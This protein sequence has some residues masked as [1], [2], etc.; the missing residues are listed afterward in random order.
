MKD[1]LRSYAS[2]LLATAT[3][4]LAL[5]GQNL[6]AQPFGKSPP[7]PIEIH[8]ISTIEQLN[9]IRGEYLYDHFLLTAD[10]DFSGYTYDD[11]VKGW[12]PIGHDTDASSDD[13]QGTPFTGL[14]DGNGHVIRNLR[15]DRGGEDSV[16]LFGFVGGSIVSLGLEG[17]EVKGD[18]WVG[19]IAGRNHGIV[20]DCYATGSV[21]GN[22]LVG[23]LVGGNRFGMV[24][25]SYATGRVT[26]NRLVGGLVGGN[27]GT[28]TGSYAT[29][30][31]TGNVSVGGLV[32]DIDNGGTVTDCYATGSVTGD[33]GVG[34]LV[35]SSLRNVTVTSSYAT[36]R[37]TGGY[38]VGGVAGWLFSHDTV[39]QSYW[40]TEL[41]GSATSSTG[42][43]LT[44][45]EMYVQGSFEGFDFEGTTDSGG[46][47]VA[48]V[49][50]PPV[51]GQRFPHLRGVSKNGQV[52][53]I[54]RVEV[55]PGAAP[56]LLEYTFLPPTISGHAPVFSGDAD[57]VATIDA[58]TGMI[59]LAPGVAGGEAVTITVRRGGNGDYA[60][61][62]SSWILVVGI[63]FGGGTG[64]SANPWQIHTLT[65][66]N[67]IRDRRR[68][69]P[70]GGNYL[71]DHFILMND[72]DFADYVYDSDGAQE[73]AKGWLPIGHDT[74]A[75]GTY[76]S[77]E[78]TPFRGSFDGNGHVIRNLRIDRGGE[79]Y[80][81]LFGRVDDGSIVS[82]GLEDLEVTGEVAV[83][84]LV[85]EARNGTVT[86]SYATG[87][88]TGESGVGG[89][90]GS[91]FISPM[92]GSYAAGSVTGESGVGGLVGRNDFTTVMDSYATGSVTGESNVGGLVGENL[93]FATVRGSYATGSV[94]GES[95][96]GGLV[97]ENGS[98]AVVTDSYWNT[99]LSGNAY[100]DGGVGLTTAQMYVQGSFAGFDFDGTTDSADG[101]M[102]SVWLPPV[103]GQRFPHLR[104]VSKN[105]QVLSI[106][107]IEVI[108]GLAPFLLEYTFLPPTISGQAPVFSGD[109]DT[110]ATID[111]STGRFTLAPGVAGG[112]AMT[113]TVRRGGNGDYASISVSRTLVVSPFGGGAGT[114]ENPWQIST[115]AHLNAIRDRRGEALTG[116]NLL[117]DHFILMN[118]LDFDGYVYDS[119]DAQENTKGWLPIGHDTDAGS[120]DHQGTPFTGSLSGT[121]H[122]I[123]NLRIDRG[124]EDFVGLFGWV[125][126]GWI[127]ALGLEDLEVTG[128][129][130]VGGLVGD[131][132]GAVIDC[133]ATGRVTGESGVGT[134]VGDNG[135]MVRYSYATGRVTG[136]E[137]VG[138]L[139]G[140]VDGGSVRDSYATGR[141]TGE[142]GVGGLVGEN[143][144][145]VSSSYATGRVT[146]DEYVG[147]LAGGNS[148]AV[149]GSYATGR[150]TGSYATGRVTGGQRVGGL[151]GGNRFGT[152]MDS[153]AT[154]GVTGDEYVGGLVGDID[155]DGT[156]TGS[157]ATGRVTGGQ[158]V[159][160]LVGDIDG[161]GTVTGSYATGRVTGESGVGGLVGEN[162]G[163]TVM[164]SYATGRV[165]GESGV[166]GLVGG[167]FRDATVTGSYWNTE[168]SGNADS[169]GGVGLTTSEMYVQGNFAGFDFDGTTDSEGNAV[170]SVW[171]PPVSGQ[172]FPH[173]RGVSKNGQVLSIPRIGVIPGSAS[174]LLE[175]TFLPPTIS[176]HAPVFSG[177]ADTVATINAS[178]GRITLAPGAAGGEAVTITVRR[179]GNGEYAPVSSSWLLVVGNPFGGGTG[180]SANPWQIRTLTHLNDIRDRRRESPAGGNYLY[181]HFILMDDLDFAGYVYDSDDPMENAK[182]WLP[183]GHDTDAGRDGHQGARFTGSFDGDGLVIRNLRIDRGGEDYVGLFGRVDGGSI[184]SLGLEDLE[185][186]GD[187]NVGGLVGGN[188]DGAVTDSYATGS[189]TGD[190]DVGG[191]VGWNVN[192]GMVTGSYATGSVTGDEVV[193]GLVGYSHEGTVS[194][195]YATGS[196]TGDEDVGGLVGYSHEGTVSGSYATGSVTGGRYV[197]GLVGGLS[198]NVTVTDSYWNTELS[199]NATS[200]RGVGLTTDEMYVQ[201]SFAGF[202]FDGTTDSEDNAVAS[203][204]LPPVSGQRFPHLRGVSK[205]GQ[206]LSIPRVVVIPGAAPFLLEYTFLPP[207]ISRHAPVFSG[208]ADT[209]ATI[210]A[211]TGRIT[212][213][214]GA[215]G[216][217]AVTI[218]VRRGGNGDYA[219]MSSS[220]IL[221][222]GNPF[223]EGKGTSA[224]PWQI[225][226]LTHLNAIRDRRRESP[227][228]GNF[229]YGHFILMND[230]DFDGYVY[231]S[232]DAQ[233]NTKGWLPIGH[234][235]DAG[236]T[237]TSHEGTPFRG[238]FDGDGHVIQNLRIDR[239]GE[240]YMG[241]FGRV[242]GGSIVSLG[243]EDL[244]V[245]GGE[246]VGG[247]AGLIEGG[248]VTGS[249]ATGSVTGDEYVGGLV[250]WSYGTV[251][252]SYATGSV[253]GSVSVGGLVGQNSGTVTDSYATGSVTGDEYVGGLVG[254]LFNDATVTGSYATGSVTGRV[255]VGGLV[256]RLFND[257]TVTASYWNMELSG[258]AISS[259]GIGL[260]MAEMYVQGSFAGFDFE[261]TTDPED[262]AVP[263][264]WLPPVSG[265]HFPHLRGVSKNGQVLSIPP[266]SASPS[267]LLGHTF[268][269]P[270]ISG[271][272]PVFS[273]DDD[274][275]ATIDASTGRITLS[276]GVTSGEEMTITVRRGGDSAYSSVIGSQVLQVMMAQTITISEGS[277]LTR[278]FGDPAFTLRAV[279]DTASGLS[280]FT[281]ESGDTAVA[282]VV[283]L[284]DGMAR[285]TIAGAGAANITVVEAGNAIWPPALATLTLRVLPSVLNFDS[286]TIPSRIYMQDTAIPPLVLPEATGGMVPYTY[287]LNPVPAGLS[288]DPMTRTLT[289][290]PTITQALTRHTYTVTD[291][292]AVT[293]LTASLMF[294]ITVNEAGPFGIGGQGATVHVY[295]NPAGDVLHIEFPG[296]D[297]YGIALLTL[298]GQPVLGERH[299]GGGTRKLDVSTLK[300]GVYFLKIEDSEGVS[301]TFRIIR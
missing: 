223:G 172:H 123:R 238:S 100:S 111:A 83:G 87:S 120:D 108:P 229:L 101:A 132:G 35:G 198:R 272:D 53:S 141:V 204:W 282:G 262:N 98:Q 79:D 131:N 88:V 70:A 265:Q 279:P 19:G 71:Y 178:T 217:E 45:D 183:I 9:A 72:L 76:T 166:G 214:P 55:I 50:L 180:T 57:T 259:G 117:D 283:T 292:T 20:A 121:G 21:T 135:G 160:G 89:L 169:D 200:S 286:Q 94:T 284:S 269:P 155:N 56:F 230:L 32:G 243:L 8:Q 47:A 201:G 158:R 51:S 110:V 67:A 60:P 234:D 126:D 147:G 97:G 196:V 301:Q 299:A 227:A 248:T 29:E 179:G 125:D 136:K 118:D 176:G 268:L 242:D 134:L 258:N 150:V 165:T 266:V 33:F 42:V 46:T 86:D 239:G 107:R 143:G 48:S 99:E 280:A 168:L 1:F 289:G 151:V 213:A 139:A 281:W 285:V 233:E 175:Y 167:L 85:G 96:V 41:S 203:A 221:V 22:R 296:A 263:S 18:S 36:G 80:V 93:S 26:G 184:V 140:F 23:G 152:V 59:T 92:T 148:T 2:T 128:G 271:Q 232:D 124:G 156:V 173:L 202:D 74:D 275:V 273:G 122:V 77:Y 260:T 137:S 61:M 25:G 106:P 116:T 249:Y 274:A 181:D 115:L 171:L 253:T 6:L 39:T 252:G 3:L 251:T 163:G 16:G 44:T 114:S 267:F 105:G 276:A 154:G 255:S 73:N 90:A 14:F 40:N 293:A 295:P 257:A 129:S 261:G 300:G 197:G 199:G 153:Y 65:H 162:D 186:T 237:Y 270:T 145:R 241:L 278:T 244:E 27:S 246:Y 38:S 235:T 191:L 75:G 219:P 133:Y 113:I 62:S 95:N 54:P 287:T 28:V 119:G 225:R 37:V 24:T 109:A 190:E 52:I 15:I 10:L 250:G 231:D 294:S 130:G 127:L 218:T 208:D 224:N 64:T 215:G 192:G 138:G 103:S 298:T 212:L 207:T 7:P 112:E 206:V 174:F 209:V 82:L 149:M 161:L 104:G 205:N 5:P 240:D 11:P 188:D 49:W 247:L 187:D 69:S 277:T 13:H 211:S 164:G 193:G 31:V 220:W 30:S 291:S 194:G 236:S 226:T 43:G 78:G 102:P 58:T 81:G 34:G 189:V 210:N 144:G 264:M 12:L 170:A 66:L 68:E 195:S 182:G 146:G 254:R 256:G 297:E 290:T 159:G 222:V 63:P 4:L 177:D 91:N 142:S 185:V 228:R 17:L 245:T 288:F 84:G 216:G 157:Y